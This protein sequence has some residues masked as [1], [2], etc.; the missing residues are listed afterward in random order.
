MFVQNALKFLGNNYMP[1]QEALLLVLTPIPRVS[2]SIYTFL[3][4]AGIVHLLLN[5]RANKT[6]Y[7]KLLFE[8]ESLGFNLIICFNM[9]EEY[10]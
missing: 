2:Q 3:I 10:G 4:F 9:N 8:F 6:S 5:A 7:I 1:Q